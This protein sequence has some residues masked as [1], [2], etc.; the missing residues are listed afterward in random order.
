MRSVGVNVIFRWFAL[1]SPVFFDALIAHLHFGELLKLIVG[2]APPVCEPVDHHF[3]KNE[4]DENDAE[5]EVEAVL[6]ICAVILEKT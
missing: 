5:R 3:F 1:R 2:T 6:S 4:R